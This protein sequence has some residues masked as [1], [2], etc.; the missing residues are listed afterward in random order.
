MEGLYSQ[1]KTKEYLSNDR[2][3]LEDFKRVLHDFEKLHQT[4]QHESFVHKSYLEILNDDQ[5]LKVIG[6]DI[7]WLCNE[8]TYDYIT[9][10]YNKL[11]NE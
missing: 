7:K 2:L 11:T 8:E 1:V 4:K 6:M 5:F 3:T 10:R 9:E